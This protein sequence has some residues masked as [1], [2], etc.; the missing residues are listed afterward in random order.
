MNATATEIKPQTASVDEA[1]QAV[2]E[3]VRGYGVQLKEGEAIKLNVDGLCENPGAMHIGMWARQGDQCLFAEH[4]FV[5]HGTCNEAEYLALKCGLRILQ[6]VYPLPGALVIS[7]TVCAGDFKNVASLVAKF[8]QPANALADFIGGKL[9]PSLKRA[10]GE[11]GQGLDDFRASL[12]AELNSII[13]G[14]SLYDAQGFAGV[15]LRPVTKSLLDQ[16]PRDTGLAR[17]NRLLLEDAFPAEILP[18]A[19]IL[20]YSDS[21]LVTLQ[22]AGLWHAKDKMQSY[23]VFLRK[24]RKTY[25]YDLTKISRVDNQIADSLAQKYILKNSGRCM[26]IDQGRF[27]VIKQVPPTVKRND[28]YNAVVPKETTEFL[29]KHN[30]RPKLLRVI[31]LAGAGQQEEAI[32]EALELEAEAQQVLESAPKTNEMLSMWL[33]NTVGII[34]K[35]VP[36]M[37]A[38]IQ[39]GDDLDV[40]YIAEE[41]SRTESSGSEIYES[42]AEM[43]MNGINHSQES[44]QN[45]GEEEE[46]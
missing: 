23:C 32:K 46:F 44:E 40:A 4:M 12:A 26:S 8:M 20:S 6:E 9:P 30:L 35:S 43:A 41:L 39:R 36:L 2:V 33:R 7:P 34:K 28:L 19:P 15:T 25:L 5:G 38:A 1:L 31:Q 14:P 24:M 29:A 16:K 18:R 3:R 21:Q 45:G 17:L 13:H 11:A 10:P 27:N 42:Q 37:I 22:V